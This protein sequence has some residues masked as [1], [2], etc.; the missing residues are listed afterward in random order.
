MTTLAKLIPD[1]DNL[2]SMAP[3]ELGRILLGLVPPHQNHNGIFQPSSVGRALNLVDDYRE[4]YHFTRAIDDG[5]S[6]KS[7]DQNTFKFKR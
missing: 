1:V 5:E 2:L 6:L 3:D 4:P 7:C